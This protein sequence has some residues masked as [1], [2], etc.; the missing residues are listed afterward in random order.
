[1]ERMIAR[2]GSMKLVFKGSAQRE[3]EGGNQVGDTQRR[4]A[5]KRGMGNEEGSTRC[6]IKRGLYF[7]ASFLS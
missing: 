1:M 5:N 4:V 6:D 3:E 7:L 2:C